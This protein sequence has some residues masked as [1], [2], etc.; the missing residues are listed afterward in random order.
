MSADPRPGA[1]AL[2]EKRCEPC[3]GGVEP[4]D[5]AQAQELLPSLHEDWQLSEDGKEIARTFSF[6]GWRRTMAFANAVSWV[7]DTEGHHPILEVGYGGCRVVWTTNAIEG[8]SVNDFICAAKV[9]AL[10]EEA[11]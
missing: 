10:V 8:L 11:D 1:A 3:E 9:D 5:N 7:A 2:R 4:L 6:A